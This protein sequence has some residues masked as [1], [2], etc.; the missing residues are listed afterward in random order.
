MKRSLAK[1]YVEPTEAEWRTRFLFP[2][3]LRKDRLEN[4]KLTIEELIEESE[5][6]LLEA[7]GYFLCLTPEQQE[8]TARQF[9]DGLER[10]K[11]LRENNR[12]RARQMLAKQG[13][14]WG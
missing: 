12:E 11:A 5:T 9:K 10:V 3:M 13:A 2:A 6:Q 14:R 1:T 4:E 7:F 8:Q